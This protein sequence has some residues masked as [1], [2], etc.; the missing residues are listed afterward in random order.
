MSTAETRRTARN[1]AINFFI[2]LI[3]L[4]KIRYK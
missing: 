4:V 2:N 3:F 1:A